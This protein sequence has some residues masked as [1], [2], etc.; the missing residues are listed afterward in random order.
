M[1]DFLGKDLIP[2][3]TVASM[4]QAYNDAVGE[5]RQAYGLL[6]SAQQ[7]LQIAFESNSWG[8]FAVNPRNDSGVGAEQAER[9][10][11]LIRRGSVRCIM[12]K[13][14][15]SP[16]LSEKRRKQMEEQIE[17][18][19][20]ETLPEIT[21]TA[22]YAMV[23]GIAGKLGEY[24]AETVDEVYRFL[25][26]R[27]WM[28]KYKTNEKEGG[29]VGR[30]VVLSMMVHRT[31]RRGPQDERG[32]DTWLPAWSIGHNGRSDDLRAVDAIFHYLDGVS[33]PESSY[34]GPLIDAIQLGGDVGVSPPYFRY[35]CY[36]NGNLHLEFLRHDLVDKLN[37]M[38]AGNRLRKPKEE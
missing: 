4:V 15:I 10:V 35:K 13:L 36:R 22:I 33:F 38:A 32:R 3:Q 26:P 6:E 24:F 31:Q 29:A 37:V 23:D 18:G 20:L 7:R 9:V 21:D 8:G 30:K 19:K 25:T 1:S 14:R 27:G 2:H 11:E 17:R 5:I 34:Y 12:T 28:G 16:L